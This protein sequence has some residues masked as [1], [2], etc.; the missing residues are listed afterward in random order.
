LKGRTFS[1]KLIFDYRRHGQKDQ[2]YKVEYAQELGFASRDDSFHLQEA[3]R[4]KSVLLTRDRDSLNH[5]EFPFSNLKG[6]R[7]SSLKARIITRTD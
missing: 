6:Q 3:R 2:S 7:L 5:R 1:A 4:R